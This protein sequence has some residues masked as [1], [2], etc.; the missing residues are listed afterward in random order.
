MNCLA[1][2]TCTRSV[3][4]IVVC[5]VCGMDYIFGNPFFFSCF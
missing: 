4:F 3:L 5:S 2:K 1:D